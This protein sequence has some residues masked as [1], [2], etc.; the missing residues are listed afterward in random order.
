MDVFWDYF[1]QISNFLIAI[2]VLLIG[3]LVATIVAGVVKKGLQKT[4]LDNKLFAGPS[5][6]S[7]KQVNSEKIIS[8][9]VFWLL[10]IFVFVIFLNLLNLSFIAQP[11][12]N[13][14]DDFL[15][16][17]PNIVM[18]IV[19]F[20]VA[21]VIA[22]ALSYLVKTVGHK[23]PIAQTFSKIGL[24]EE[25]KNHSKIVDVLATIVFYF[26][27]ILFLPAILT[28]LDLTGIA[29][30]FMSMVN[31]I[32]N[33]IPALF[34]AALIFIVGWFVAKILRSLLTNFLKGVGSEKLADKLG[35]SKVLSGTS[36]A[37]VVGTVL[38]VLIMIPVTISA[39][40][41]LDIQ[42]ITTPA[43]N[44]LNDIMAM[45]PNV[46]IALILVAVGI[47]I[48]RFAKQ[49]VDQLLTRLGFNNIMRHLGLNKLDTSETKYTTSQISGMIVEIFIILL[50][51]GEALQVVQLAFFSGIITAIVAY[52]PHVIAAIVILAVAF[53][54]GHLV[55]K[56]VSSMLNGALSKSLGLVAKYAIIVLAV[57]MALNQ[58]GVAETI[59][60]AAF[61]LVLGALALAFGLAFGLGG[62]DTAAKY[63]RKWD[64]KVEATHVDASTETNANPDKEV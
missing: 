1:D 36:L 54:F 3:W 6:D 64:Q 8:Q 29:Q 33:F 55:E 10:M 5:G 12:A 49:L 45:L 48:G 62:R 46:A 50:F 42:G 4:D 24:E 35:L 52:L 40:E 34:A 63:L 31:S 44:M 20:A 57:F 39:L 38:F 18:A 25:S 32:L 2:V 19:L 28:T 60:N 11:F 61:V 27:F 30:P 15:G 7:S 37:D 53:Y 21:W 43:I 56:I 13:M 22:K 23:L 17:I 14:I 59:V 26:V 58:L 51:V 47:W 9:F 16:A 41:K